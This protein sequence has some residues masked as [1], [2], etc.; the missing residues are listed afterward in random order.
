MRCTVVDRRDCACAERPEPVV[1]MRRFAYRV[2]GAVLGPVLCS[3]IT[4]YCCS[5]AGKL[6]VNT[7]L[8]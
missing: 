4:L 3:A 2:P 1:R 7:S 5:L 8:H 6:E